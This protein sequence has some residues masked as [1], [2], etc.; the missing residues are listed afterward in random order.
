MRTSFIEHWTCGENGVEFDHVSTE[1]FICKIVSWIYGPELEREVETL[2]LS[3][4]LR[5][6]GIFH[7]MYD[8]AEEARSACMSFP[9][10]GCS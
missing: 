8:A 6:Y 3:G 5:L 10:R 9:Q 4:K 7:G 2:E 1:V